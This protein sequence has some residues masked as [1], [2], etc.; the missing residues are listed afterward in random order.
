MLDFLTSAHP[1]F[2]GNKGVCG[3]CFGKYIYSDCLVFRRTVLPLESLVDGDKKQGGG[4]GKGVEGEGRGG[5]LILHSAMRCDG[6]AG[7]ACKAS[8]FAE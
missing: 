5:G 8:T 6:C 1:S 7:Y 2:L 3:S 4:M